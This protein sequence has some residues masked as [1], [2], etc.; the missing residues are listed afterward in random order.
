[1]EDLKKIISVFIKQPIDKINENTIIDKSVI[2]GSIMIHRMYSKISEIG[3]PV[4]DYSEIITYG[5]LLKKLNPDS[6]NYEL[7]GE[8][9]ILE[10]LQISSNNV[11]LGIDIEN[12]SNFE[13]VDDFRED[14]FYAQNFSDKEIAYCVM[15]PDAYQ[16]FAGKFAA[17]EAIIKCDNNLKK[18]PFNQIEILNQISGQP[19]YR[20]FALSISHSNEIAVAIAILHIND[21]Q[22]YKPAILN[23]E[24]KKGFSIYLSIIAIVISLIALGMCFK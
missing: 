12:I 16:S 1:M 24:Q 4:S 11:L 10:D 15:Q 22:D 2:Q 7:T 17:K 3:F 5:Q 9:K 6:V 20:N 14:S 13:K 21:K 8:K 19:F 23:K 18:I